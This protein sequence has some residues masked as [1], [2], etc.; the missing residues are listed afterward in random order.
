MYFLVFEFDLRI[1][2]LTIQPSLVGLVISSLG[3]LSKSKVRILSYIC[4]NQLTSDKP[5]NGVQI[6]EELVHGLSG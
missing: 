1:K 4:S 3:R 6:R 2:L 5:L